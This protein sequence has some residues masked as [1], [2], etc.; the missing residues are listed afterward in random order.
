VILTGWNPALIPDP[1]SEVARG[2]LLYSGSAEGCSYGL[3]ERFPERFRDRFLNCI[4]HGRLW[5]VPD[6]ER[7]EYKPWGLAALR[8]IARC[9][10][11]VAGLLFRGGKPRK[12]ARRTLRRLG[13]WEKTQILPWIAPAEAWR[14]TTRSHVLWLSLGGVT[15]TLGEP[16]LAVKV[17]GYLRSGRP[18][19]AAV[20]PDS[21]TARF[22]RGMPGAFVPDPGDE[23]ALEEAFREALALPPER[24]FERDIDEYRSDRQIERLFHVLEGVAGGR[25]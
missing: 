19:V 24:T 6:A 23:R 14:E 13:L 18:I 11:A 21:D 12:D 5:F 9:G 15:R 3:S 25:R 10:D 7:I 4:S 2:T 8:A 17:F 16:V 1:G 22:L 20:P